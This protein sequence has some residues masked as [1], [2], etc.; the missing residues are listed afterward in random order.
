MTNTTTASLS[1]YWGETSTVY[2]GSDR[3]SLKDVKIGQYKAEVKGRHFY[4]RGYTTQENS[5]SSYNVTV[6]AQ[7]IDESWS[8]TKAQWA[9]TYINTYLG[10]LGLGQGYDSSQARAR[11]AADAGRLTPGSAGFQQAFNTLLGKAIPQGARFVDQ[12]DLYVAEGMYDFSDQVKWADIT[13]GASYKRYEL[14]SHGTLFVD[15]LGRIP[16][17]EYGAFAQIQKGFWEDVLKVT[18]AGR[19]DKNSNFQGRF[20]PRVT[21]LV[22]VAKDN[23]IRLSY[24]T[25]YRF[26]STQ[27]QYIDLY[28]GSARLIGGLPTFDNA[29]PPKRGEILSTPP[30][31]TAMPLPAWRRH[32][33]STRPLNRKVSAL[34][35]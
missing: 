9:P 11:R 28:T 29:L 13:V 30:P 16:I 21:A 17:S 18:L 31:S 25:A 1:A 22:K 27:N 2:S 24:Q 14:N 26:P 12:T 33:T 19:Y 7:L 34:L 35:K 5:G 4:V 10:N 6:M 3:Y 23:N 15:T 20:T 8:P 32:P